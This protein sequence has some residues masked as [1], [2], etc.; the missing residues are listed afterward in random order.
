MAA[1]LSVTQMLRPTEQDIEGFETGNA[2]QCFTET[3]GTNPGLY[4]EVVGNERA[5]E[6]MP[7]LI[8]LPPNVEYVKA[9]EIPSS[10]LPAGWIEVTSSDF[11]D[12]SSSSEDESSQESSEEE[13]SSEGDDMDIVESEDEENLIFITDIS[14]TADQLTD[15]KVEEYL[16]RNSR[17][18]LTAYNPIYG[19]GQLLGQNVLTNSILGKKIVPTSRVQPSK[20]EPPAMWKNKIPDFILKAEAMNLI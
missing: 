1:T 15:L 12:D 2:P 9:P 16:V 18:L 11:A 19:R 3:S 17:N 20:F 14:V 8:P 10:P 13:D 7:G 6:N 5:L 4:E